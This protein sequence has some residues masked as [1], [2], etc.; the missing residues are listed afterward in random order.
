M[1]FKVILFVP[2][3]FL[4]L[5]CNDD[6]TN[7][8]PLSEVS[9]ESVWSDAGL[10]SAAV[11]GIYNGLGA[12][13]FGEQMMA[14]LSDEAIF[15]HTGRGIN[16]IMESRTN[17]N[18]VGWVDETHDW[19][20]MYQYIRAANIAI[21]KMNE[22]TLENKELS[23]RLLGEAL[24]LRAYYYH[25][26]IRFYGGVALLDTPLAL[27]SE[28]KIPRSSFEE[29]VNF[30]VAD[31][32][33]A[34]ALLDGVSLDPGRTNAAAALALKSRILL[35]AA[36]D[37]HDI[38]V[39]SA[40]S[41][42]IAGYSNPELIAYTSGSQ[43]ERWNNARDAAKAAMDYVGTGYKFGLQA[44]VSAEE[45]EQN[46]S[47]IAL[48]RNGG[49]T[50]VIWER[51]YVQISGPGRQVGLF[52]GPNGY[53]NWAGNTPLQNLVDAYGMSDGS[54][55]SW[56][57]PED[58]ESPYLNRDPRFYATILYDGADWKP[59][60]SDAAERD[61]ANQ[62]QTGKYEVILDSKVIT[63]NGLD[64]REGPIENWNGTRTGYYFKKFIN[65][66]DDFVDQN[67]FQTIPWPFFRYTEMVLNYTEALLE[68]GGDETEAKA[69]LNQI[70]FRAGM[71]A[72]TSSGVDLMAD[73]RNERLIEL[74]YEAH[75]YHDARRWMIAPSTIGAKARI[76]EISGT[77]KPGA[78]V[79]T[80]KYDTSNYNYSYEP[81]EIDPGFE[82]RLWLDKSYYTPIRN[83][84]LNANTA[85]I[86]NPG[87]E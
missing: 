15:T 52:N 44:P 41:S 25:Q 50:D 57:D 33:A 7:V 80:Y 11:T 36:S 54:E 87:Y 81:S 78:S 64:T 1:K 12:G 83:N 21:E 9:E 70:R 48:S 5:G 32:D 18:D 71:P 29:S 46:Y 75:R 58:S 79:A 28:F 45:G 4:V 10:A 37:L 65:P 85:L 62:I 34:F 84:E 16:T 43:E 60:P 53:H 68:S 14:S 63:H 72:I 55:F 42:V 8:T 30:V 3:L 86:Q 6:F 39:A 61:P 17:S 2:L 51:Q 74:A 67:E 69:W 31:C 47:D 76:I 59:R 19:N 49:E 26:L 40:N 66:D 82:N 27:D 23:D 73:Y 22:G 13:G 35:Y 38:E 20:F 77:L 24:Y 56:D